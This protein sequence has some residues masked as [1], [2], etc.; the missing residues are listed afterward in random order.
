MKNNRLIIIILILINAIL[1]CVCGFFYLSKDRVAPKLQFSS[2]DAIYSPDCDESILLNGVSA[3]DNK[4][5]DISDRIVIE[6]I[7]ENREANTAVIYYAVSDHSGNVSKA[8]REFG[9]TYPVAEELP[10][11]IQDVIEAIE[12]ETPVIADEVLEEVAEETDDSEEESEDEDSEEDADE[13]AESEEDDD[14]PERVER[15]EPVA[16][17]PTVNMMAPYLVLNSSDV[18][19]SAGDGIPWATVI[20]TMGDDK[21]G[22]EKLFGNLVVSKF[23]RNKPGTYPVTV[24]T[25]DS[26]GYPSNTCTLN[27]VVR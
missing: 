10:E 18:K 5:G 9:A 4:D 16:N 17:Q 3:S 8:S 25:V 26:D 13:D 24:Y 15:E 2:N 20:K 23:D 1:I 7:V 6:K 14:E 22:Y 11:E 21:D 12:Q 27:V 19:I